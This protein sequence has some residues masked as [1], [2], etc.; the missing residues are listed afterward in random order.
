MPT[1]MLPTPR[2]PQSASPFRASRKS[3]GSGLAISLSSDP[4]ATTIG[5]PSFFMSAAALKPSVL[6]RELKYSLN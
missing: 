6:E 3:D 1:K 5:V 2:K 4:S